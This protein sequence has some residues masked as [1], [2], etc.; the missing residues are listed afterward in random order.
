MP[1]FEAATEGES[2]DDAVCCRA[3][4]DNSPKPSKL[5]KLLLLLAAAPGAA[6]L[7]HDE[8]IGESS[9]SL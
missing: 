8:L 6:L 9:P 5:G 4:S 7:F 1:L 3:C 2:H